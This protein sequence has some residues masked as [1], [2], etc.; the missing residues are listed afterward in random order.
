M[1]QVFRSSKSASYH[2]NL[3][4]SCCPMFCWFMGL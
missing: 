4:L 3:Q 1:S 2:Y